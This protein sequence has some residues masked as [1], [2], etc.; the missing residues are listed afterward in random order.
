MGD[1]TRRQVLELLRDGER[2]V[3]ELAAEL[4]VSRPAVSQH[5]RVL[6]GAGLVT[7]R[8]EGTRHLYRVDPEGLAILRTYL[9][10]MWDDSLA[11]FKAAAEQ[12]GEG[13]GPMIDPIR[14]SVAGDVF[15]R[16]GLRGVHGEDGRMVAPPRAQP[17]GGS[18]RGQRE[19]RAYRV[20]TLGRRTALRGDV[21]RQRGQLGH[22]PHVGPAPPARDRLEAERLTPPRPTEVDVSFIEQ[23]DG[24]TRVDLEHRGWERLGD[25]AREGREAYATGWPRTFDVL[26]AQAANEEAG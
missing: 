13:A 4:P 16:E 24:Q 14:R 1:P 3:V 6:K 15:A 25:L 9:E 10:R 18:P 20:G 17:R 21:G 11:A 22:D 2:A 19:G 26:F 5:L 12:D 8:R 7:E 23:D